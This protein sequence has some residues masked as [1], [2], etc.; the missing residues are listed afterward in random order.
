MTIDF[1]AVVDQAIMSGLTYEQLCSQQPDLKITRNYFHDRRYRLH[2]RGEA[3][4]YYGDERAAK[5][6]NEQARGAGVLTAPSFTTDK[7][8]GDEVSWREWCD[9]M[10]SGQELRH[11]ASYSQ[12]AAHI[13]FPDVTRP[14]CVLPFSDTHMGA[15]S[16][17]VRAFRQMTEEILSEPDLYLLLVGDLAE[18]AI[19]L[20]GVGEVTNQMIP[21]ELQMR[22]VESWL[23]EVEPHV[24]AAVWDNHAT[25]REEGASGYSRMADMLKRKFI[26]S[27]GI[28]HLDVTV[29][30]QTYKLAV[31]HRFRG[32]SML[33]PTYAQKRYMRFEGV[34][35][36]AC[37]QGDTHVPGM[38]K[39]TDGSMTRVAINAGTLHTKSLYARRFFSLYSHPDFPCLQL[40]PDRHMIVPYWNLNEWRSATKG[41]GPQ[42]D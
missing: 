37:I 42:G 17:D 9:W 19:R 33:D 38:S 30:T 28:Q 18:M 27:D 6:A 13:E 15:W 24:L 23:Q 16:A 3:V 29:A 40:F 8:D 20:R 11:E 10:E 25:T 2:K 4:P 14:I 26:Y 31:S 34:D 1:S 12:D 5:A 39:Y 7:K 21:P 41:A 35:R 36:E 32:A 22:F